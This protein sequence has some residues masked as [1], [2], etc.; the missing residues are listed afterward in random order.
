MSVLV[1]RLAVTPTVLLRSATLRLKA[2]LEHLNQD[3][4]GEF[5]YQTGMT[6]KREDLETLRLL[7]AFVRI[8]DPVKRRE[9]IELVQKAVPPKTEDEKP[10]R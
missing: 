4:P 2:S 3:R 7:R 9:I 8:T 6:V 1:A 10:T 5:R